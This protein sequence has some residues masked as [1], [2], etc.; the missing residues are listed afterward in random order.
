MYIVRE[1]GKKERI[2]MQQRQS[3]NLVIAPV[4][5]SAPRP[6]RVRVSIIQVI[7]FIFGIINID[8]SHM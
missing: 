1:I 8:C 6:L 2:A 7:M 4:S 5:S 3:S